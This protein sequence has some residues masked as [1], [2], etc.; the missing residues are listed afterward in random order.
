MLV[1]CKLV[2]I[3]KL[4]ELVLKL[5]DNIRVTSPHTYGDDVHR[6]LGTPD[7]VS[8]RHEV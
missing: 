8:I 7:K 5:W 4:I 2:T 6:G 3:L 1:H